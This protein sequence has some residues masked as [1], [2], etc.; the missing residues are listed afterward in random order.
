MQR[1]GDVNVVNSVRCNE[2]VK[3]MVLRQEFYNAEYPH[4]CSIEPLKSVQ[5]LHSPTSDTRHNNPSPSSGGDERDAPAVR[6]ASSF[7]RM[8]LSF[9][10]FAAW[11]WPFD[12]FS[13]AFVL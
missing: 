12:M 11:C 9:A 7:A 8:R 10:S 1:K 3:S 6:V 4:P 13:S 2:R 5:H